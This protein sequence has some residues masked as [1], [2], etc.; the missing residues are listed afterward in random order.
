MSRDARSD[1]V[2]EHMCT[3]L[4][5][6][7]NLQR[8]QSGPNVSTCSHGTHGHQTCPHLPDG[9]RPDATLLYCS[10]GFLEQGYQPACPE[11]L[12]LGG[13]AL[14]LVVLFFKGTHA[15]ERVS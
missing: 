8:G 7:S 9:N 3:S 2:P 4:D 11:V 13:I 12:T 15:M 10:M 6:H 5:T 14:S 1:G